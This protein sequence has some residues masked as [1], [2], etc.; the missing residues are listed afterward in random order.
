M[1][2]FF[3]GAGPGDPDLLTVK[4][5]RLLSNCRICIYAGSLVNPEIVRVISPAA[6]KY[7]SAGM[8]LP[9]IVAVFRDAQARDLDVVRLHSGD[10]AIYSAIGE[11]MDELERLQ[12]DYEVIPGVSAFQASAAAL[13]TELTA[14]EISQTII[15][16][17]ISGRTPL[18]PQQELE[19]LAQTR[20]TLCI[21]LSGDRMEEVANRLLP[22]YGKD[23]PAAVVYHASWPDQETVRGALGE[24]A[25][26][27][28]EAEIGKT[29]MILIGRALS[30]NL[31]S[32]K[33]YDERFS[34]TFRQGNGE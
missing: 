14:P 27:V 31:P 20:S 7:D 11:Q 24:I 12:I 4:A 23:C 22:Y 2:V 15:L 3:V 34:H 25:T 10:P 1:K 19:K 5:Q 18:P 30:R 28:K 6:E 16:T 32:S 21:F 8:P 26:K 33:L 29:S 13:R 9:E 17:R